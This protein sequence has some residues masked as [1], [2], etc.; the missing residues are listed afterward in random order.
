MK[1]I[2][3]VFALCCAGLMPAGEVRAQTGQN[4]AAGPA[5]APEPGATQSPAALAPA[6]PDT[7]RSDT[8]PVVVLQSVGA[9][10]Y[11]VATESFRAALDERRLVVMRIGE[12]DDR[13]ARR[14]GELDPPVLVAVGS[15]ATAWALAQTS[16]RPIVFMM[17]LNPVS[18]GLVSSMARP[19]GRVTG[20]SLDI[21]IAHQLR[22]LREVVG[23]KRIAVV[24]NPEHTS[25]LLESARQVA[26][27]EG[28]VLDVYGVR[29]P[30]DVGDALGRLEGSADA[31]W[32]V[33]DRTV[34]ANGGAQRL[35]VQTLERRIPFM[36]LSEQYVR[37]GALLG[38]ETSYAENGRQAADLVQRILS[39]ATPAELAITQPTDVRIHFNPVTAERLGIEPPP[40]TL[41]QLTLTR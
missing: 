26:A 23:A 18:A 5:Q 24:S 7:A 40:A 6:D 3:V 15:R 28:L 9:I 21:P 39:G 41:E 10:P 25:A 35:L 36:G 8:R 33:A 29:E 31:L 11:D 34:L 30:A 20:A 38:L 13:H 4:P 16:E 1:L 2:R 32:A 17:V 14:I 22:V 27:R 37:A 12:D 19:D